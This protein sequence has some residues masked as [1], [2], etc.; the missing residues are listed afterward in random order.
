MA[1]IQSG[2]GSDLAD[3]TTGKFLKVA[4]E[5]DVA[6]NPGNVGATRVFGESDPGTITGTALLLSGEVSSDYRQRVGVDTVVFSD[7]F[8]ATTQN[9]ANWRH[10]FTTM[11]MTQSAG[12]LNVNAAGTSTVASNF[13]YLQSFRYFPVIGT[14]P[15]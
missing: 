11:T 5:T 8:N 6:T 3:V 4:T 15:L 10:A 14:A 2:S 1:V 9:T 7:T 13:A 12:F